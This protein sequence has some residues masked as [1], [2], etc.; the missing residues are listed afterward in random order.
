MRRHRQQKIIFVFD[1]SS[2]C[3]WWFAIKLG[4][5][6]EASDKS[7]KY[8]GL[9]ANGIEF[10]A[11]FQQKWTRYVC[12]LKFV[13]DQLSTYTTFIWAKYTH[14]LAFMTIDDCIQSK[15]LIFCALPH[16]NHSICSTLSNRLI[17]AVWSES[18]IPLPHPAQVPDIVGHSHNINVTVPD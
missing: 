2:I 15:W 3:R 4:K 17:F 10:L 7:S 12:C 18:Q 14:K 9:Q 16:C 5:F 13:G 8:H 1:F 11:E 6:R